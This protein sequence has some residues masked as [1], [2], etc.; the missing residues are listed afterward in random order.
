MD[1]L[2]KANCLRHVGPTNLIHAANVADEIQEEAG[3]DRCQG[4]D[5]AVELP[6]PLGFCKKA[7]A[8]SLGVPK[9][10]AISKWAITVL[11]FESVGLNQEGTTTNG[12]DSYMREE[13]G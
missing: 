3:L 13:T 2:G 9:L 7:I 4:R 5:V 12:K 11:C 1:L 6:E 8:Q 10:G